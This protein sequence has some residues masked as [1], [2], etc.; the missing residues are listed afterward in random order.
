M[1]EVQKK[2][3]K[4]I[5]DIKW[6]EMVFVEAFP[7]NDVP[8]VNEKVSNL[9][10]VKASSAPIQIGEEVGPDTLYSWQPTDNDVAYDAILAVSE[11][12]PSKWGGSLQLFHGLI[13]SIGAEA[14]DS[15]E[16]PFYLLTIRLV[17]SP[18]GMSESSDLQ[19]DIQLVRNPVRYFIES[20]GGYSKKGVSFSPEVPTFTLV[21]IRI[22]QRLL[23]ALQKEA[24]DLGRSPRSREDVFEHRKLDSFSLNWNKAPD[25]WSH[26][27][28]ASNLSIILGHIDQLGLL[29]IRTPYILFLSSE[30]QLTSQFEQFRMPLV[31]LSMGVPMIVFWA[32]P[33]MFAVPLALLAWSGAF[34]AE[35]RGHERNIS[36]ISTNILSVEDS[37]VNLERIDEL[38]K[39]GIRLASLD[40]R[41]GMLERACG[42]TLD[43]W[44]KNSSPNQK[45]L[46][47]PSMSSWP[48][49][50]RDDSE[51]GFLSYLGTW[52][53]RDLD[54]MTRAIRG[55]ER[56][57]ELLSGQAN[58]AI[59]RKSTYEM[60]KATVATEKS[61]ESVTL[62][63]YVLVVLT[64]TLVTL[65]LVE[66]GYFS[67]ALVGAAITLALAA[68]ELVRE[69]P[70]IK[71]FLVELVV[72]VFILR[73]WPS[74]WPW[75]WG[76]LPIAAVVG[77]TLFLVFKGV[78]RSSRGN[79]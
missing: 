57:V 23:S 20:L 18:K 3:G 25:I 16:L 59:V 70:R 50:S 36:R 32:L 48:L 27:V 64:S 38:T 37:K 28:L 47:M 6:G 51:G 69:L 65:A 54:A 41:I 4:S 26:F 33:S 34:W 22:D 8:A 72:G 2:S 53:R 12:P 11:T 49:A 60:D 29:G 35:L 5:G 1:E 45:E 74:D 17:L 75:Y 68:T 39:V 19:K 58:D 71:Y 30:E 40:V 43:A 13:K 62:M 24:K 63:T 76:A 56:Q 10:G 55:L 78:L 79:G 31:P 7:R 44:S 9:F 52:L 67:Y 77:F 66:N 61:Q 73:L 46:G 14:L 15:E 42:Q 21:G